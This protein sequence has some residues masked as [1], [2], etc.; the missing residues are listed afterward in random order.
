[1]NSGKVKPIKYEN[2]KF[3]QSGLLL[4]GERRH[5]RG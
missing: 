3:R 2:D 1:M 5:D 4:S